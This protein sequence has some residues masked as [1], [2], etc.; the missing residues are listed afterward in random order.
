MP[1][2]PLVGQRLKKPFYGW[3]IV[4]V[5]AL[6]MFSSGPGQSFVFS[7][8]LDSIIEDTGFSRTHITSL[9]AVGTGFSAAMVMIVSRLADQHGPRLMVVV[10][11]LFLGVSCFGMA[12]ATGAI[13]FFLAFAALRSLGQ[14]SMA[15]NATLVTAQWFV[16][17]RGR[18]MAFMSL[19]ATAGSA[20]LPP[21]CRALIDSYGWRE[22]YMALGVMVWML[23]IPAVL[24][25]LRNTPEEMGLHPDGASQPPAEEQFR[26]PKSEVRDTRKVF[27]SPRFWMLA[28]PL[29]FPSVLSTALI[30]H[31]T[32][33][34]VERGLSPAVGAGIFVPFAA[35]SVVGL[36]LAGHVADRVGPRAL[37]IG[38]MAVLLIAVG[39]VLVVSSPMLAVIYSVV[40]GGANGMNRVVNGVT[41]AHFYGRH[42]LGR[43][44]GS[45]MMVLIT[46]SAIGP[47]PMAALQGLTGTFFVGILVMG[48][49]P[50]CGAVL[51]LLARSQQ[52]PIYAKPA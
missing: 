9:Y 45:A 23:V 35:S 14:G 20:V 4:A 1:V 42:G 34:V 15:I 11:A 7:V 31:Q 13:A 22:T 10:A 26:A 50:I 39:L 21:V 27:S 24:L 2:R 46:A 36:I 25:F 47:L 33:I 12:F 49:L 29:A 40:L 16:R 37:F 51:M 43:I 19:G 18:A 8:F 38:N 6:L 41:M 28:L 5:G 52:V 44:Q 30:F 17:R 48:V 32:S 3:A